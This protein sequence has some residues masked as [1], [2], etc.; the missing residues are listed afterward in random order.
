MRLS[1]VV[2]FVDTYFYQ[3][4]L[5]AMSAQCGYGCDRS[6]RVKVRMTS[7]VA[8]LNTQWLSILLRLNT[9]V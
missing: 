2:D 5:Y 8:A 7:H 3:D 1:F 6:E 4:V 9:S